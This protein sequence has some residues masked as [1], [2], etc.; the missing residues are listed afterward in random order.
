MVDLDDQAVAHE[1]DALESRL[2]KVPEALFA[3]PDRGLGELAL[4]D[5]L[6][7]SLV[8]AD[9]LDR[10]RDL[11]GDGRQQVDVARRVVVVGVA[12]ADEPGADGL[13]LD[14]ERHD[15]PHP[16][17]RPVA[18][19]L[20]REVTTALGEQP[21]DLGD[22]RPRLPRRH[23][24]LVEHLEPRLVEKVER[25]LPHQ[26]RRQDLVDDDLG[27]HL[28]IERRGD[29]VGDDRDDLF[30]RVPDAEDV[31]V[32]EG[33]KTAAQEWRASNEGERGCDGGGERAL[34]DRPEAPAD[35]EEDHHVERYVQGR[36]AVDPEQAVG[37]EL[38]RAQVMLVDGVYVGERRDRDREHR[39]AECPWKEG[40]QVGGLEAELVDDKR[41]G[42][43]QQ[44]DGSEA[45]RHAVEHDAIRHFD[46]R[47]ERQENPH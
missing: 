18:P 19:H 22:A 16:G 8:E 3:A 35:E 2:E 25:R 42:H 43:V 20:G 13:R 34:V 37:P 40:L 26:E 38:E 4:R 46:C 33:L 6:L 45:Q 1:G 11:V 21:A 17:A 44:D 24:L 32:D 47:I 23:P 7:R 10:G 30:G 27:E 9:V 28:A 15:Q 5:L 14:R 41:D 39:D 29:A 36:E 31:A 12:A